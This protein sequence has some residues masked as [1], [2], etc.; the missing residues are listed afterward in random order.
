M[1]QDSLAYELEG[2]DDALRYFYIEV[3]SGSLMLKKSLSDGTAEAFTVST[4]PVSLPPPPF[5]L[6][7]P[8]SLLSL[9]LSDRPQLR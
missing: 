2:E 9:H 7:P 4:A 3:D 8:P 6:S 5:P 1:L